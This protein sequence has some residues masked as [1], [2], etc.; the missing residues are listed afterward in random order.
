MAVEKSRSYRFQM[1]GNSWFQ[2]YWPITYHTN[3]NYVSGQVSGYTGDGA[4]ISIFVYDNNYMKEMIWEG[5]TGVG[6]GWGFTW[7][8]ASSNVFVGA[9]QDSTHKG[10]T[11]GAV[12]TSL[13]ITFGGTSGGGETSWV[14]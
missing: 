5:S 3:T 1:A 13:N 11:Q 6:G 4:G 14:F 12:D 9:F 8:N 10:M 2:C 7:Y